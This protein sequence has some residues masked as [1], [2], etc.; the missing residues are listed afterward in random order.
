[1]ER[2]HL[3]RLFA[4]RTSKD[5]A[6]VTNDSSQGLFSAL[7][8]FPLFRRLWMGAVLAQLGQ[9]MQ[10]VALGWVALELTDSAFFVGLVSFMAGIPF[11][12]V[13]IPAGAL[14]DRIERRKVLMFCQGAAAILA[15]IVAVDVISGFVAPWH[16]LIAA[17]LNGSLLSVLSPTQQA[18][19]PSLVDREALT[20]AIGLSSAG[21]NMTR[22]FGPSLAGAIIGLT[23]T[24]EAFIVQALAL[25]SAFVLIAMT[26]FPRQ[27]VTQRVLR[28]GAALDGLRY[29][30]SQPV[31]R[32]LFLLVMIPTFFTFP[33]IQ[34]LNVFARDILKIGPSGLGLLMACS[35]FGA[36]IGSLVVARGR[37][38]EG[39]GMMLIGTTIL[40]A[41]LI[42]IMSASRSIWFTMPLLVASGGIG[43][44]YMAQNNALVQHR[45][46]EEVRGRVMSAYMLNNGL[47][48]LGAMPMGIIAGATSVPIAVATGATMTIVMTI[49]LA[50]VSPD[51]RKL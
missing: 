50:V 46:T 22:V 12:V 20:N 9:W 13:A 18:M 44:W 7:Q 4:A 11:I 28:P 17:F 45:I 48:P 15:I 36:V 1:M 33:Y 6:P 38:D 25:A 49:L 30:F 35:G 8:R 37:Q 29:I 32:G 24:G 27:E 26:R 31:L 5:P 47:L 14:I 16:L 34:F 40:Y 2:L 3:A 10:T 21:N 41:S 39:Q 23:G 19:T 51:L 42:L 43:S